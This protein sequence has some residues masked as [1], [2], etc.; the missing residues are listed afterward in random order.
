LTRSIVIGDSSEAV[1]PITRYARS[2]DVSVAY[3]VVGS[4]PVDLVFAPGF[5]SHVELVWEYPLVARGY[6]RLASFSRLV[7]FDKRGTGLSDPV[8]GPMTLEERTDDLLAVMDAAESERAAIFG[9]SEGGSMAAI[10]AATHPERTSSL[11][12]YGTWPRMLRAPDFPVG[13]ERFQLEKLVAL[14]DRWGEGVALSSFAPSLASDPGARD[15]WARFQRASASPGM[16]RGLFELY[17][18]IDIRDILPAIRAETLVL[19]RTGD[20]VV[21][22]GCGRYLAEHIPRARY[23]ELEGDDHIWVAGDAD[24]LLDEVEEFVTGAR[25]G[26]EPDRVLATI[27]FTDIV[28]STEHAAAAGDRTW[29]TLLETHHTAVRRQLVRFRGVEI[30]TAGDG[31]FVAFDGPARAIRCAVAIRDAVRSLGLEIRAG[32]HTGECEKV[33]NKLTGIAVN[34]GARVGALAGSG[35]VLVSSTVVDLVAG[36]GLV[37]ED[38]GEHEL[39]GVPGRRRLFAVAA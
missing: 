1:A 25:Q 6:E 34:I 24:A 38:R 10:F 18:E 22:V 39:R 32:L 8:P 31:F 21:P 23:V 11:V 9:V 37:F 17:P 2:G 7:L 13:V 15:W 27:L 28:G 12:L 36:S 35:E 4:G 19:H 14:T 26:P 30:D 5:I 20:R 29:A 16:A 3:Q 33:G